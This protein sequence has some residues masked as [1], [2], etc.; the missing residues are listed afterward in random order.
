MANLTVRN[1]KSVTKQ[2]L[3]ERAATN[4]RSM[5]EEVRITLDASVGGTVTAANAV[6]SPVSENANANLSRA[7]RAL[8]GKT[9]ILIISGGIAAYKSLDLIRR[10]KARGARVIPVMTRAAGEFITPLSVGAV[11]AETV[12]SDLFECAAEHDI[13]HIRLAR[14]ADLIAV[15]P[16]SADLMAKMAN[17]L[18]DDLATAVLLATRLPLLVAPAMNPAMWAH[19]ATRDNWRTLAERGVKFCGP[20]TGEMAEAGEAGVGRMAEPVEIADAVVAML[21]QIAGPKPLAGKRAIVTSGPTREPIDPVRYIANHSS[22]K[23]GHAIAAEL[24]A[25]G[26][27]VILVCGPVA[28]ADPAECAVVHVQTAREMKNAVETALPADIAVMVAAVADWRVDASASQKIKKD[29]SRNVPQLNLVENPDILKTVGHHRQRPALV[30]GFAAETSDVIENGRA[31]LKRKGADW[32]VANDVSP[33]T[34]IMGGDNNA[35]KLITSRS[36]ENWPLMAKD[37]VAR[38]L[39]EKIVERLASIEV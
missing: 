35:V 4:G 22:G 32:I 3:R 15:A 30:V 26:A 19:Q 20:N 16:A 8:V 28:I 39:V 14:D 9:I 18:A 38:R 6:I 36:V 23:Q 7:N 2:A 29:G 13:G 34:G 31:K 5:E 33:E 11:A 10:L 21:A 17:G 12:F 37:Q 1:L 27:E 24:A 25:A